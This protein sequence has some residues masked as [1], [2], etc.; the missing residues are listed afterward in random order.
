MI[1]AGSWNSHVHILTPGLIHAGKLSPDET[2]AKLQAMFTRW[3]FTTVFHIASALK[4]TNMIRNRN[5]D[6]RD[7]GAADSDGR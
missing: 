1:T 5:R 2:T 3:C 6:R 7:Q 4:N